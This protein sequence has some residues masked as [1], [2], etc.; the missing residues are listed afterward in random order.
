MYAQFAGV[1]VE[2]WGAVALRLCELAQGPTTHFV[3]AL[4]E[5]LSTIP[6]DSHRSHGGAA[7]RGRLYG[8]FT[9]NQWSGT[10]SHQSTTPAIDIDSQCEEYTHDRRAESGARR[11]RRFGPERHA[12]VRRHRVAEPL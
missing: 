3:E 7:G 4:L 9:A 10:S 1:M 8:G 2:T 12:G 11:R 6:S 5:G